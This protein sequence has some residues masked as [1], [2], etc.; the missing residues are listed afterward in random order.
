MKPSLASPV[1]VEYGVRY[2]AFR[3]AL[4]P[5]SA[6]W[7]WF[8]KIAGQVSFDCLNSGAP[9]CRSAA[10]PESTRR[11]P[12]N[13]KPVSAGATVQCRERTYSFSQNHRGNIFPPGGIS[14]WLDYELAKAAERSRP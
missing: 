7:G 8:M 5:Q 9:F 1:Y 2:I 12:P 13:A 11:L 4:R 10:V 6:G 14:K 3:C